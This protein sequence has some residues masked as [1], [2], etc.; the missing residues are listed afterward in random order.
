M[1][2][3]V[4]LNDMTDEQ[5]LSELFNNEIVVYE[6][7]QGSKIFVNWEGDNF[8]IRSRSITSDPINMVDLAMQN[9]YNHAINYFNS[10]D[11][12]VKGLLNKNWFFVFEYFPDNQPANI[13]YHRIPKNHLVLISIIKNGKYSYTIDEIE[14]YSRLFNVDSIPVIFKGILS[15]KAAEAIK[16]F[17]NTSESDLEYVFGDKSFAFFFY[18]ILN[19]QLNN[20]FLMDNDFQKNIEKLIIQFTFDGKKEEV[21]ELSF[22]LLNPLYQRISNSNSTEFVEVYSLILVNFLN[23]CQSVKFNSIK[24]KGEKKEEI[25]I[26]LMCKL[27][28]MYVSEVKEDLLNFE[29]TVPEFFDKEKFRINTELINNKLTRQYMEEN[30]KLEYIFKVILGSF[31]K[32]RK[33][34]I[35][36]FTENTITIFNLFVDFINKSI[37]QYLNKKSETDLVKK[38]LLDFS[39]FFDIKY[40]TDSED[41]VYPSVWDEIEKGDSSKKK[42]GKEDKSD[43]SKKSDHS[44]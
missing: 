27:F 39:D 23:F 42:K 10:I 22:E 9:Y 14:E 24:F 11:N 31:N 4:K 44:I 34:P 33:K 3:L 25:Y 20:S 13:Q 19:P 12:R 35:G 15:E 32:K 41:Q 26:Y 29:F 40:D 21:N 2:K 38:G 6:D 43:I 8:S 30:R 18:K 36:V 16:Y 17:L 37:D 28:N 7:I 5:L 1:G